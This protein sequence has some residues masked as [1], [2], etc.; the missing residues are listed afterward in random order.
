M[1]PE[2][3]IGSL[4]FPQARDDHTLGVNAVAAVERQLREDLEDVSDGSL[5]A[6]LESSGILTSGDELLLEL[7]D[8]GLDV[9][10][11][12]LLGPLAL[13]QVVSIHHVDH[14]DG[15]GCGVH[16]ISL[17]TVV[18]ALVLGHHL[19]CHDVE[20]TAELLLNGVAVREKLITGE[21]VSINVH[22]TLFC[23]RRIVCVRNKKKEKKK[24]KIEMERKR[25]REKKKEK[26]KK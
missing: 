14:L 12:V 24:K 25:E 17:N 1:D 10:D 16:I 6:S 9:S 26:K 22:C 19:G 23:Y 7:A 8:V 3:E 11:V 4:T 18:S 5:S 20:S 13:N 15:G 21:D 2:V